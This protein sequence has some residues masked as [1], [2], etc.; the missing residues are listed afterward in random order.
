LRQL[1]RRFGSLRASEAGLALRDSVWSLRT[2]ARALMWAPRQVGV[3][4]GDSA[5]TKVRG[6]T[7][8]VGAVDL[9]LG[10]D[11]FR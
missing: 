2:G 11:A 6:D 10:G 5:I 4:V 3:A 7:L 9:W 8:Q 1:S